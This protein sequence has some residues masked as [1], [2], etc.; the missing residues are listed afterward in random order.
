MLQ[1]VTQGMSI[2]GLSQRLGAETSHFDRLPQVIREAQREGRVR[3]GD[4]EVLAASFLAIFQGYVVILHQN[5]DLR[6]RID[7]ETFMS[8]LADE[9]GS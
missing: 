2:P 7:A 1:A 6:R 9:G 8:V 4:A 3:P 5:K